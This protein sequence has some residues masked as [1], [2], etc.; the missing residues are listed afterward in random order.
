MPKKTK[1]IEEPIVDEI[2]KEIE[3]SVE[4]AITVIEVVEKPVHKVVNLNGRHYHE[5]KHD[6][7]TTSLEPI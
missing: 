7:G 6:D 3:E 2:V 5:I 1:T 4:E